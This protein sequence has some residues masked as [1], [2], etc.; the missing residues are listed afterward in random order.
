MKQPGLGTPDVRLAPGNGAKP[1]AGDNGGFAF[2]RCE[3]GE[4]GILATAQ[5]DAGTVPASTPDSLA[6]TL[7]SAEVVPVAQAQ[8]DAATAYLRALEGRQQGDTNAL[9]GAGRK[10]GFEAAQTGLETAV[11]IAE[12]ALAQGDWND[13]TGSLKGIL[14]ALARCRTS[15]MALV[16][17]EYGKQA[18]EAMAG[19][20]GAVTACLQSLEN[21]CTFGLELLADQLASHAGAA[22]TASTAA[23]ARLVLTQST[24]Q[25]LDDVDL[26]MNEEITAAAPVTGGKRPRKQQ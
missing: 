1:D 7:V 25:L 19:P 13:A 12:M 24:E 21:A 18:G 2:S 15:F 6:L 3:Y 20:Q 26:L 22:S 4:D 17:S 14:G 23:Q 16:G 10:R 11:M 5:Q 9:R 8:K